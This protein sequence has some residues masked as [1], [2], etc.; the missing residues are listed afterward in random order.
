MATD[1]VTARIKEF[2]DE[3]ERKRLSGK[4]KQTKTMRIM[5]ETLV[6]EGYKISYSTVKRLVKKL[7]TRS[8]EAY[9]KQ[10]HLPGEECQFDWCVVKL[11]I[12]EEKDVNLNMAVFVSSNSGYVYAS[13]S[14]KQDTPAF[15]E[16]HVAFFERCGGVFRTMVYD[17][18]RVM[19]KKIVGTS[20]KEPTLALLLLENHYGFTHRFCNARR[21]NEKGVVEEKNSILRTEAFSRKD[22]FSSLEEANKYLLSVCERMNGER[23]K[24]DDKSPAEK[25]LEEKPLLL[26]KPPKFPVYTRTENKVDKLSTICVARC[27][28]S[29]PDIY[30][31]E[32]VYTKCTSDKVCIYKEGVLV[33]AHERSYEPE[34]W[35][36]DINHYVR[37]LRKKPG[38]L[39]NCTALQQ[40]DPRVKKIF[41]LYYKTNPKGFLDILDIFREKG[42]DKVKDSLYI[43][44]VIC[45]GDYSADKVRE[46]C[47]VSREEFE[48]HR[49]E[50]RCAKAGKDGIS[51]K[52]KE[53]LSR[54]D[55]LLIVQKKHCEEAGK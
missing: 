1:E 21:G 31:G 18:A 19:M 13:L 9:I 4:S 33:A 40:A 38:A 55:D 10:E 42:I 30:V 48:L 14:R 45:P 52:A 17:N 37:T 32:K 54:Y 27:H 47:D 36:L 43:L 20:E 8:K 29:V 53:T 6:E 39:P 35:T 50:K 5:H 41:N 49:A 15:Q 7:D 34:S 23:K 44:S 51:E 24:S 28:Y 25:F 3:N 12:G 11:D 26:E 2:L 46:F 22:S 16:S